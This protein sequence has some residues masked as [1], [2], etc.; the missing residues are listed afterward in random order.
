MSSNT[1]DKSECVV[2]A[3]RK[4]P[5]LQKE[6]T[7][8][9]QECV[10]IQEN[11]IT[12]QQPLPLLSD[13]NNDRSGEGGQSGGVGGVGGGPSKSFTFD[14]VIDEG[15]EQRAIYDE[16][17]FPLV[18]SV[19]DGYNGTIF[20][21]GQTGCGKTWTMTGDSNN[22]KDYGI[23]PNSFDHI[24]EA[25]AVGVDGASDD[26]DDDD[27]DEENDKKNKNEEEVKNF[28]VQV[29]Y[30]EIYNEEI[31]DLLVDAE[32]NST[33]KR[34]KDVDAKRLKLK[35]HPERGVYVDGLTF[36]N[37]SNVTSIL[38]VM[39]KGI[40]KRTTAA[41][42]MNESSS[43]S[44]SIFTIRI[45]TSIMKTINDGTAAT[46]AESFRVGTL[47]LVDLAGSERQ[48]TTKSSGKR[49]KE[50]TKINLSLSA[51]GNVISALVD[52]KSNTH[53]P[54]RDSKLTRL[55]QNSLGG[56]AKTIMIANIG[57]C[58]YSFNSTMSTLRYA[59]R[60]KNIQN[61]PIVNEDPKE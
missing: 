35:E 39:N 36:V 2:V 6:I 49:L 23:I 15:H 48:K 26:D 40:A 20:A 1:N 51:L 9:R 8:G 31:R 12:I 44:H 34:R 60:A 19:I 4:R 52:G 41:T 5:R 28:L 13:N 53:V 58:D 32:S 16:L 54:Y 3:V 21:Y 22:P 11:M 27:D 43:R 10:H 30:L 33:S 50:G 47:N 18:E 7:E 45:E 61:K 24:F 25:V 57:P 14:I 46:D 59:N 56:N 42:N 29:S 55:L 37:V 17:A 38:N